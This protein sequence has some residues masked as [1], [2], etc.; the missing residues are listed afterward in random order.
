MRLRKARRPS[1]A[2]AGITICPVILTGVII[3]KSNTMAYSGNEP[4]AFISYSHAD[5]TKVEGL[6][7][8]FFSKKKRFWYDDGVDYSEEWETVI[9]Q[10]L[11]SSSV[12][13][14]FM[15]NG[16][17]QRFEIIKELRMA[18]KKR[19]Q[20]NGTYRIFVIMLE[21]VP[22]KHL[23]REYPDVLDL[24][25]KVQYIS[26]SD[27][28]GDTTDFRK[29]ICGRS[30]W[31]HCDNIST[32]DEN[33][34]EERLFSLDEVYTETGYIYPYAVPIERSWNGVDF[35]SVN[36][37]ETD[38][39]AVY[40]ICM[41]NQ[42]CPKE[43]L[44]DPSFREDG[45][46]NRELEQK[47][48][49]MQQREVIT[50]LIHNRQVII[51]RASVVNTDALAKWYMSR[52]VKTKEA[53]Y[54]LLENGSFVIYLMYEKSPTEMPLFDVNEAQ[55]SCWQDIC[56]EHKV[57]CIRMSWDDMENDDANRFEITKK[58][59]LKM[60][61]LF[62]TTANDRY[63]M[64][65]FAKATNI[66]DEDKERFVSVW[67]YIRNIAFS[68]D[69][70]RSGSYTRTRFYNDMLVKTGTQIPECRLD[71]SKP[72]V[73]ELKQIV[74][75]NYMIN[76]P[77][78]LKINPV[79]SYETGFSDYS[80]YEKRSQEHFRTISSDELYCSVLTFDPFFLEE[81]YF[82]SGKGTDLAEAVKIRSFDEWTSYMEALDASRK[83]ANLNEIDFH[84]VE[85]VWERYSR[86]ME[87]CS[88][89]MPGLGFRKQTGSLSVIYRF[90]SY[91]LISVYSSDSDVIRIKRGDSRL[92]SS[93]LRENLTIDFACGD[94][95][96]HY[97]A[98][99]C[100]IE[101][102]RLFEGILLQPAD[103]A[104]EKTL[105]ALKKNKYCFTE[106]QNG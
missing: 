49:A 58:I 82:S 37:G 22:V 105:T 61:E 20:S 97:E 98:E 101:R 99:N 35:Y 92:L 40:P 17:E 106:D 72:F 41:D 44:T 80:M 74:D 102:L 10:K 25:C 14:L 4:Y 89:Q 84:D 85:V 8:A 90:G 9:A 53:F 24:L 3:I 31:Q 21:R 52:D 71:Y 43:I 75:Y 51:N 50:A 29:L 103:E 11:Q 54:T 42:W 28:K 13:I 81:T 60:Q 55:Y 36:V 46:T 15:T 47:R 104:F 76:L 32:E 18:M 33:A 83:R 34:P 91:E 5:K 1:A 77:N 96:E 56:R 63:R 100:F 86:L 27:F 69:D 64:D 67:R 68:A 26:M 7:R 70:L 62:L 73:C 2:A 39:N 66:P 16:I 59:S 88:R 57:Y 87:K 95:L 45:F 48:C 30:I 12:F 23:F 38:P 93:K 19:E 65:A 94:I 79:S 78:A 6:L